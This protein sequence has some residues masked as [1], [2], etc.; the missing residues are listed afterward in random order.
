LSPIQRPSKSISECRLNI[1]TGFTRYSY[2]LR[3]CRMFED[4]MATRCTHLLPLF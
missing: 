4:P 2:K 1:F 3:V